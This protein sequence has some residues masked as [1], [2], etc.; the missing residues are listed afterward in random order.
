VKNNARL[1]ALPVAL[2]ACRSITLLDSDAELLFPG[3]E[4][5]SQGVAATMRHLIT[6][7]VHTYC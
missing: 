4:I 7:Q 2:G 1:P 3:P 5:T 6:L